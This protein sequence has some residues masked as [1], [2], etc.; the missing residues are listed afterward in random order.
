MTAVGA[1]IKFFNH[2]SIGRRRACASTM[3]LLAFTCCEAN[4]KPIHRQYWPMN[5]AM[6]TNVTALSITSSETTHQ[7]LYDDV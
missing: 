6:T 1:V 5:I 3:L 7:Q 4:Q 2:R